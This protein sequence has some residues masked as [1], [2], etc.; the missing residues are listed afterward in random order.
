MKSL[1]M[2]GLGSAAILAMTGSALASQS[3]AQERAET[4]QLNLQQA[5]QGT[6]PNA[7]D[8]A[9]GLPQGAP[10]AAAPT[11]RIEASGASSDGI[12]PVRVTPRV[13]IASSEAPPALAPMALNSFTNPPDKVATARVVDNKGVTIGAVQKVDID[14]GKATSVEVALLG[15]NR[16]ISIDASSLSY[17]E[18]NNVLVAATDGGAIAASPRG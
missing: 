6:A 2:I 1:R 14:G 13:N 7:M 9:A 17:D 8:A 3:T 12:A 15:S 11:M 5:Q 4:R 10:P 16:I 18:P